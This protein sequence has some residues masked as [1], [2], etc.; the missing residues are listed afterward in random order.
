MGGLTPTP[1][2]AGALGVA[3]LAGLLLP[4]GLAAAAAIILVAAVIAD[5]WVVRTPPLVRRRLPSTLSRG[6]AAPLRVSVARTDG[7]RVLLRQPAL[8]GISVAVSPAEA[9]L[10][11]HLLEGH[12]LARRRGSYELPP[13]ASASVG[14]LGLARV[15][16]P[17][18]VTQR[19][20]VYPDVVSA[21][22]LIVRLRRQL[23]GHQSGFARGPLGLGTD[24][25]SIREYTPDDDI[26]QLNWRASARM[27]R[28][29]SNQY[30]LERDRDVICLLDA[31][32]LMAAPIGGRSVLDSALDCSVVLAMAADE[33]GDRSG[34]IAFDDGI[35]RLLSPRHL[36]ARHLVESLFDLE[37]RLVDSDFERAF[38]LVGSSR[39]ALVVVF[40]DLIDEAAARPLLAATGML[41]RRH[42]LVIATPSDPN[43]GELAESEGVSASSTARAVVALDMLDARAGAVAQLR[44]SGATVIE[45]P[46]ERLPERCL[47]AYLRMKRRVPL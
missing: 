26:R 4:V 2:S 45:A 43:L 46:A 44:R 1:R 12:L 42:A 38:G 23:S 6:S 37:P 35:R 17:P 7:R 25:E 22:S 15:H 8:P 13:V 40:T 5:G 39:R 33:L 29:M 10:E 41:A 20:C 14:P 16:H 19:I 24:F 31:G 27:G 3:A 28:P 36:G 11:G 18:G 32:R 47:D 21:H 30:R 9:A 34:A